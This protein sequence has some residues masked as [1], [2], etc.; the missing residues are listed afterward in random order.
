MYNKIKHIDFYLIIFV[1]LSCLMGIALTM[2][3]VYNSSYQNITSGISSSLWLVKA[4]GLAIGGCLLVVL[5]LLGIDKIIKYW[6]PIAILG[7][8][9]TCLTFTP[10]GIG[11]AGSDDKAW[12]SILGRTIQPSEILKLCFIISFSVHISKIKS[13]INNPLVVMGLLGH[14]AVPFLICFF[15]GDQGT[16]VIFLAIG[17]V[18]II[19]AG[20]HWGYILTGLA[21]SPLILYLSWNYFLQEHQKE[22]ILVLFNPEYDPY[23]T[24]YQQIQGIKALRSGGM[25]GKGLFSGDSTEFLYVSE[26][27]NDFIF[28]YAGQ[29]LGFVGCVAIVLM[30]GAICIRLLINSRKCSVAGSCICIGVFGLI[31]SHTLINIGMVL[32]FMPVIGVPLPFIS[33]GGTAMV[34]MLTAIGLA[35]SALKCSKEQ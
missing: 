25:W 31:F 14:I 9:F 18:M 19:G 26:A 8:A 2:S 11:P 20:I 17:F 21:C 34:S 13:K 32:G 6:I 23:G 27:Q 28:S 10:L 15:Q 30:L 33:A 4:F 35:E 12:I 5:S 29:T 3:L 7:V 16:G 22:R 24:G 1:L